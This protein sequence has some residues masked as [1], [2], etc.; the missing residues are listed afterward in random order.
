MRQK[1]LALYIRLSKED[2]DVGISS[3]KE[4]SNSITNQRMLLYDYLKSYPE[5]QDYRI[6]EKCDDGYSGKKFD[7][8]QFVE[9][10]ELVR[11]REVDCIIVK[12]FPD[13]AE[14]ILKSEIIW[15]GSFHFWE[16][17]SLR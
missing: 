12:D 5:F 15:N 6:I 16:Y 17:G 11:Q 1:T 8:P 14:T 3:E 10:M 4:E 9:L 2:D 7:R 13:S